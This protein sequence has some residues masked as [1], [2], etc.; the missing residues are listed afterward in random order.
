[1]MRGMIQ[2]YPKIAKLF[3]FIGLAAVLA[4][5]FAY[6]AMLLSKVIYG[7]DP[8]SG[9]EVMS[10]QPNAIKALRLMQIFSAIGS[11]IIPSF[12]FLR[13]NGRDYRSYLKLNSVSK[14]IQVIIT[15]ALVYAVSPFVFWLKE[16][17]DLMS[18]PESLNQVESMMRAMEDQTNQV[19]EAFLGLNSLSDFL[20]NLIMAG[21]LAA[22][23]EE[24]VFRGML[25]K[26]VGDWIK[27][28][29]V[30]VW[31]TAIIFSAIHMQFYGFLPRMILGA[32][33]GYVFYFTNNLWVPIIA[34]FVHNSTQLVLVY[35]HNNEWIQYDIDGMDKIPVTYAIASLAV[36]VGLFFILV[37]TT[38]EDGRTSLG[39]SI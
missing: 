17:N 20:M 18:L 34:H 6:I 9:I 13:M 27:N 2:G 3:I 24:I 7:V 38:K 39:E 25:Q 30:A 8:S 16:I 14:P 31:L 19:L 23:G 12:L 29:H 22:V 26:W 21:F 15:L 37:K 32:V 33:F 36:G 28:P 10:A 5:V 4:G 1:M 11:F 35:M